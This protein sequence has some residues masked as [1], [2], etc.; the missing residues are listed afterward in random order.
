M[1]TLTFL[2]IAF[3]ISCVV[4]LKHETQDLKELG[5]LKN[6]TIQTQD[7]LILQIQASNRIYIDAALNPE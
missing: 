4:T 7:S 5:V 1:K 6:D 2:L 3:L